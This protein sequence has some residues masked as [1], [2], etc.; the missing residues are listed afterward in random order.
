MEFKPLPDVI[1]KSGVT[2][3]VAQ[4]GSVRSISKRGKK[5]IIKHVCKGISKRVKIAGI[6]QKIYDLVAASGWPC[7]DWPVDTRDWEELSFDTS[8]GIRYRI[9]EDSEVQN[10]N[11]Y[12]HVKSLII[13]KGNNGYM[14]TGF[15]GK[16][17]KV[18]Q[19][20]GSVERWFP[21]PLDWNDTWT[22][23]HKNNDPTNNHKEN[24]EWASKQTQTKERRKTE[25]SQ[26]TSCPVNGIA[27]VDTTLKCGEVVK[28][29]CTKLFI[30]IHDAAKRISNCHISGISA[31]LND[32]LK[33]HAGFVWKLLQ[34]D[35]ELPGEVFTS[36]GKNIQS[37]RF[38]STHGRLKYAFHNG[39]SMIKSSDDM[40]TDRM[41]RETDKYPTI[42][43]HGKNAT[44][45]RA[46]LNLFIGDIP[47]DIVVDH[48]DDI[49][50]NSR[51]GNLQILTKSEN[52]LK[53]HLQSYVMSV[54]SFVDKKHEKS[55]DTKK[56]AIEYLRNNGYPNAA[57]EELEIVL[58]TMK[59]ENVPAVLYDRTWIPAHFESYVKNVN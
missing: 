20:M 45:H 28:K 50:V 7:I 16:V 47:D 9:F 29:E 59:T 37:E 1:S 5:K 51:L 10:M 8:T 23:H 4:D 32:N 21:K 3:E 56:S 27:L 43:V 58:N 12:G 17:R 53:R 54:V 13:S 2:Y 33:T 46:I 14:L 52:I 24:L 31:C 44:F 39:Y 26:I 22:I 35:Y 30:S 36:I 48:I 18:H 41:K 11:Q 25:N 55:H 57:L 19:L 49:K 15:A 42:R 34:S 38:I 40:V 6:S